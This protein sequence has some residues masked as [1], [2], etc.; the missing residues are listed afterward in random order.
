[1]KVN[2]LT[3]LVI[4]FLLLPSTGALCQISDQKWDLM[5]IREDRVYPS[6][7]D[8]Y[9]MALMD[10]KDL[11][12]RNKVKGFNYFTHLQDDYIFTH[13]TP[14][15]HFK[16]LGKGIHS[17]MAQEAKDP[18]LDLILDYLNDAIK[19]YR[20][21]IVQYR[22]ELSFI[23]EGDDW[24][25]G[26]P[27]RKWSYYYFQPGTE[28]EVEAV[29]SAWKKLYEGKGIKSG[30]RVFSGFLGIEQPLYILTT[31]AEDPLDYHEKL[32]NT[33]G[34]LGE[35]GAVLWEKMLEN[36]NEATAIEGWFL[37]QY[38][39]APGLKLAQ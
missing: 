32:Q 35:E 22:P 5:L 34:L 37:P 23:P 13:V 17:V 38:S 28:K 15:D 1:M 27:Y 9:E 10:L 31:W 16:D 12:T 39:Y 33:A 29:L 6:M 8:D 30:F 19:Y 4:V 7:T 20:Y 24:G 25:T 26:S 11:F 21:Y 3:C 2:R 18:E 14:L 36:V